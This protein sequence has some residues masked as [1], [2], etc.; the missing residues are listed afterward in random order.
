MFFWLTKSSPF[1]GVMAMK[2]ALFISFDYFERAMKL[3]DKCGSEEH[4][5]G[6]R[7][8]SRRQLRYFKFVSSANCIFPESQMCKL[9]SPVLLDCSDLLVSWFD[10]FFF[11][12]HQPSKYAFICSLLL[13]FLNHWHDE[14][15]YLQHITDCDHLGDLGVLWIAS[16]FSQT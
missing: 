1:D 10:S 5:F 16:N 7:N 14:A 11:L 8:N 3:S 9:S 6:L 15:H 4:I 2:S 12:P 13:Y